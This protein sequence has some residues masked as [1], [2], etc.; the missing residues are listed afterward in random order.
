M[1]E[2]TNSHEHIL[3]VEA[4]EKERAICQK[5]VI[6]QYD[7]RKIDEKKLATKLKDLRQYS[8]TAKDMIGKMIELADVV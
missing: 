8:D 4:V 7:N 2:I 3:S 5:E 1:A 6:L